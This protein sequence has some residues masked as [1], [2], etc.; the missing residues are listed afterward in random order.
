MAQETLLPRELWEEGMEAGGWKYG[1][2]RTQ[3]HVG[4]CR[5]VSAQLQACPTVEPGWE[6][7]RDARGTVGSLYM[8][9]FL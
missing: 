4:L 2:P 5:A 8:L 9:L 1:A 6:G 7:L 3:V